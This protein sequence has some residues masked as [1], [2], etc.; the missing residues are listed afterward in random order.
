MHHGFGRSPTA[1]KHTPLRQLLVQIGVIDRYDPTPSTALAALNSL[2]LG[3]LF[4]SSEQRVRHQMQRM[5]MAAL[6]ADLP[7]SGPHAVENAN[8]DDGSGGGG[9]DDDDNDSDD[10]AGVCAGEQST[11]NQNTFDR[12]SRRPQGRGTVAAVATDSDSE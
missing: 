11:V 7:S 1:T 10:G 2:G 6:D 9:D 8:N 12:R 3:L 5:H 4:Q